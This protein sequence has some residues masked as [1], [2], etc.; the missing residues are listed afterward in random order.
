MFRCPNT[1]RLKLRFA[2]AVTITAI[3]TDYA[4]VAAPTGAVTTVLLPLNTA[5]PQS[6]INFSFSDGT[7]RKLVLTYERV[8]DTLFHAC[9]EQ[10][11]IGELT[12]APETN[13]SKATVVR[14]TIQDPNQTNI[15]I[16]R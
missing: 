3:Q 6:T 13:F 15:E 8:L 10:V 2:S 5:Q 9:G 12:L 4:S 14:K 11:V 16:T 1:S 7:T